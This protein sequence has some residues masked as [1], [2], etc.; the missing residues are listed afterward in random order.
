MPRPWRCSVHGAD[1]PTHWVR[2]GLNPR[3]RARKRR[4]SLC[5]PPKGPTLEGR[6]RCPRCGTK[7][8]IRRIR[9]RRKARPYRRCRKCA[10]LAERRWKVRMG[11][12]PARELHEDPWVE[13]AAALEAAR[14]TG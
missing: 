13:N 4:C 9:D 6:D 1:A 14:R 2:N 12:R 3:A 5:H 7:S 8:S 11:L 10:R